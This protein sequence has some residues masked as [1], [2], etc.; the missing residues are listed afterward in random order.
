MSDSA[1]TATAYLCG[2]K[3]NRG[4]I[5]VSAQVEL[6]NCGASSNSKNRVYSIARWAQQAGK[7][8]GLVTTTRVTHASPAGK[9][10]SRILIQQVH[11][12]F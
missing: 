1:V 4:T 2:V 11:K 12:H 8:S 3:A 10:Y 9:M 5:G 6:D 7:T